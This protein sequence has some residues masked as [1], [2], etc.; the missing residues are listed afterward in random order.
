[1]KINELKQS[2][3]IG[4][5]A[6]LD[7]LLGP[8][9]ASY[10]AKDDDRHQAALKVFLKDF[11]GDATVSLSNGIQSG[12]IDAEKSSTAPPARRHPFGTTADSTT[13]SRY[14]RLNAIFESI[15]EAD[16]ADSITEYM[17]TWFDKYMKGVDWRA[18]QNVVMPI[19]QEIEKTYATDQGRAAIEKL[20]RV[21][22]SLS[23][24]AKQ[25]PAGARDARTPAP[26]PKVPEAP[27]PVPKPAT[28]SADEVARDLLALSATEREAAIAK[29]RTAGR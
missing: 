25:P 23:G 14:Q 28:K 15:V 9:A 1:M 26:E 29:A 17:T 3:K 8:K 21:A 5:G 13:E 20:G 10:F 11:I 18:K 22:F 4:E 12:L 2:K 24:P 16:G 27:K 6:L 7:I 19:I